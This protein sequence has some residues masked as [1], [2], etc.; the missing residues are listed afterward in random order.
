MSKNFLNNILK[1]FQFVILLEVQKCS[2]DLYRHRRMKKCLGTKNNFSFIQL[3]FRINFY[4]FVQ[5]QKEKMNVIHF[6]FK[7]YLICH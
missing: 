2:F 1:S 7:F 4:S 3:K 5:I 6:N